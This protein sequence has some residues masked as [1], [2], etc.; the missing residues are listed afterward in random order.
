MK[1]PANE[2]QGSFLDNSGV[3]KI[4]KQLR[5]ISGGRILDVAT[6]DGDF[7]KAL[8]KTL[9]DFKSII[10]IDISKEDLQTAQE[11]FKNDQI[12]F[13]EMNAEQLRFP[14]E[15][16]DT[17][18]IAHSL[19]HMPNIPIVLSEMQRV[20]KPDGYFI[21]QESYCDGEQT[22]AQKTDMLVH[23]LNAEIDS[24]FGIYHRKTFTRK[25]IRSIFAQIELKSSKIFDCSRYVKC[26]FC[27]DWKKCEDPLNESMVNSTLKEVDECLARLQNHRKARAYE[28][29]AKKIRER[30]K[31]Y[32]TAAP[33]FLFLIGKK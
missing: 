22:E 8:S 4:S 3:R 10:G 11:R 18:S 9:R 24:L 1:I 19:H 12:K 23:H 26:L 17:V 33:S 15:S 2:F 7:I 31:K 30:T 6:G 25:E 29:Q 5:Q 21:A 28:A 27:E 32:G 20:L 13:F 16:F 14:D